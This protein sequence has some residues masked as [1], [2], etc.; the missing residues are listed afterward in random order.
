MLVEV[1]Y[2]AHLTLLKKKKKKNDTVLRI[3]NGYKNGV[4][5][6]LGYQ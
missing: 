1:Y 6:S 3:R 2:I 4:Y 5:F